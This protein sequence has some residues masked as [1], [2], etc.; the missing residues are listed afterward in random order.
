MLSGNK[1]GCLLSP[2]ME[3][4]IQLSFEYDN[5]EKNYFERLNKSWRLK[6]ISAIGLSIYSGIIGWK[7][8]TLTFKRL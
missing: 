1:Y 3:I 7:I 2:N 5:Y 4:I 6:N 8:I